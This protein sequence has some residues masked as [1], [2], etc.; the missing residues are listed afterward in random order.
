[1][2]NCSLTTQLCPAQMHSFKGK[3]WAA[4]FRASGCSFVLFKLARRTSMGCRK[5]SDNVRCFW[6]LHRNPLSSLIHSRALPSLCRFSPSLGKC[7]HLANHHAFPGMWLLDL[8][9]H[10]QRW[11]G[12]FQKIPSWILCPS[13]TFLLSHC[14]TAALP[15]FDDQHYKLSSLVILLCQLVSW[16]EKSKVARN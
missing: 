3:F 7:R 5:I 14:M 11:A 4:L 10:C 2:C 16:N 6:G 12:E 8:S 9:I 15:T 13:D 1:M